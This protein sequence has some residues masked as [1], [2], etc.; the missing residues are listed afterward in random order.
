MNIKDMKNNRISWPDVEGRLQFDKALS[1]VTWFQVG[2]SVTALFRPSSI[3]D[4][5]HFLKNK[6]NIPAYVLG[7]GSNLLVRDGHWDICAIRLGGAFSNI[8]CEGDTLIIGAGALDRTIA[9]VALQEGL[10][11]LEFLVG[12][13]GTLGGAVAMNAGAYG[14]EIKDILCWMDIMHPNG[15]I[16]RFSPSQLKMSYRHAELPQGAIVLSAALQGKQKDKKLIKEKME[17]FLQKKHATQPMQGRTGGSTFKNPN[18]A[19]AWEL[20]DAAGCRGLQ[21]GKAQISPLHCNFMINLGGA[22]AQ[23]LESLGETVRKKVFE[24]SGV[25]LEWE[26]ERIGHMPEEKLWVA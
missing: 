20:I 11:G 7:A 12:I 3:K 21:L 23:E 13:P 9:H 6:P 8:E 10:S 4:L 5:A 1:S 18:G 19:R 25:M 2:G 16:E 15:D 26:V 24:H 22:T 17:E 14:S